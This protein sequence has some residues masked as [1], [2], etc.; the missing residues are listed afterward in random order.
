ELRI[1]HLHSSFDPVGKEA[2]A[3]KLINPFGRAAAHDIVSAQ[4][5]ALGAMAAVDRKLEVRVR[6][7]FPALSGRPT[8]GR[9]QRLA[10]A[11]R[12][13]DLVITYNWGAMNAVLAHTVFRDFLSLPPL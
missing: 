6:E 5:D 2:R 4:P 12:G 11:M 7:D 1:L 13:Y 3:A 10:Q 9:L 8:P